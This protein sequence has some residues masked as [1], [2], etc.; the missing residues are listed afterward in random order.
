MGVSKFVYF[1]DTIFDLTADTVSADKVLSGYTGHGANGESFTGT[2]DFDCNT[3][4]ATVTESEMLNGAIGYNKGV[5]I[6]GTMPNNGAVSGIISTKD[7]FYTIPQGC[8]DGS[9]KV[10]IDANEQAK[11]VPAN[12]KQGITILGVEGTHEGGESV[13]AQPKE[14]TPSNVQQT[15]V[16]DEGYDYLSQVTIAAIPYVENSNSAGGITITIG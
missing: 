4:D 1:G 13:T 7:G 14:A 9:G 8:H 15:I 12:I 10:T 5:K 16:P 11:L 3:Q 6:I 2:C